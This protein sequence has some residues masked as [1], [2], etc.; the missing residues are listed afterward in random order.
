M[1]SSWG[2]SPVPPNTVSSTDIAQF[3]KWFT[4]MGLD[5]E[6]AHYSGLWIVTA[7]NN[8]IDKHLVFASS[9]KCENLSEALVTCYVS[10]KEKLQAI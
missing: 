2:N 6:M 5:F 4:L 1:P 7:W 10:A 8:E 9:G 3:T